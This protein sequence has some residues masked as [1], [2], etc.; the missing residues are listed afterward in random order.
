MIADYPAA[1]PKDDKAEEE[2]SYIT[3]AVMG[4]RT[5]RGELNISPSV[6]LNTSIKTYS[7]KVENI[8][9]ENV[10]YIRSLARTDEVEIGI[11][12]V[13]P[14]GAATS[15][16]SFME[17]FVPLK[18]VLNIAAEIDRLKKDNAKIDS[19]LTAIN[20]KL[21]NDDFLRKAPQDIIDKE[22]AKY[23][24]LIHMKEKITE[25]IKILKEAEVKNDSQ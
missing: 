14:E 6:K 25:S 7:E 3:E 10:Q 15:V 16:K 4:I 23:E 20:R 19:A 8:L 13:K 12:V 22:K 2:M 1:L 11:N 9:K 18:G 24:E 21:L 17:I 5:I